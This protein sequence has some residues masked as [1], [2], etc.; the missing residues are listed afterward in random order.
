MS[1]VKLL[2][3]VVSL[4]ALPLWMIAC[5]TTQPKVTVESEHPAIAGDTVHLF[6]GGS[7]TAKDEFCLD[8]VVPVYR[9]E[10]PYY[11]WAQKT[12]VGKVKVAKVL[13][14]H[15]LEGVVVEGKIMNGDFAQQTH[16]A[17]LIRFPKKE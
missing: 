7:I 14:E 1:R 16:S 2:V 4:V 10:G 6:Y 8:A 12:E 15:Y 5:S 11:G 3:M 17:C 13:G 9:A